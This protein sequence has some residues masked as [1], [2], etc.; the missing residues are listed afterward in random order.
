MDG[1]TAARASWP[2]DAF[3]VGKPGPRIEV[4]GR[5]AG[6]N[7]AGTR[8]RN[9]AHE[10]GHTVGMRHS[11]WNCYDPPGCFL[12]EGAGDIGAHLIPGTP[13]RDDA[14]VMNGGT[15]N[16]AWSGFSG[17]DQV[18]IR[19]LYPAI[20]LT[21]TGTGSIGTAGNY[22]WTAVTSGGSSQLAYQWVRQNTGGYTTPYVV[23]T[24]RTLTMYV[25]AGPSFVL[26]VHVTGLAGQR[27]SASRGVN[28]YIPGSCRFSC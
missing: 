17:Y 8:R 28:V 4:N 16:T 25:N 19:T 12:R 10:F 22:T 20:G 9:M 24:S 6:V 15:A 21:L 11:N 27:K 1:N 2:A 23:G 18:A 13:E 26:T 7:T 3:V 5:F 14:S